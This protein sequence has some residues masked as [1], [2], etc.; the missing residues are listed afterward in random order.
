MAVSGQIK[1]MGLP[2]G[3]LSDTAN[4]VESVLPALTVGAVFLVLV[5]HDNP[6]VFVGDILVRFF[7]HFIFSSL[8]LRL[9][10]SIVFCVVEAVGGS[11]VVV[12]V[13]LRGKAEL[14]SIW[15]R[16]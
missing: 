15:L 7:S 8:G 2:A 5:L 16:G 11:Y 4:I 3:D 6:S 13:R 10:A 12:V 1:D 14:T 9:F